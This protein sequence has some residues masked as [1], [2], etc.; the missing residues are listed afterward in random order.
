MGDAPMTSAQTRS[1]LRLVRKEVVNITPP[2]P[3]SGYVTPDFG[4]RWREPVIRRLNELTALQPGWDGYEGVPVTFENAFFAMQVLEACCR[5]DDPTPQI[6]PG[7]SG[8]LQIE[9]HLERGDIE[10]HIL[11]PNDVRAWHAEEN[12]GFD[13]EEVPLTNDFH[14]VLRWIRNLTEPTRATV[15]AA[16]R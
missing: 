4:Q 8:D 13:G 3:P 2:I 11:G 5:G 1:R 10:L 6:V 9:W 15:T 16:S 7:T 12:T 14:I